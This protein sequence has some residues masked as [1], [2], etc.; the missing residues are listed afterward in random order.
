[1][2]VHLKVNHGVQVVLEFNLNIMTLQR[3]T[4]EKVVVSLFGL[5]VYVHHSIGSL[6]EMTIDVHSVLRARH[7]YFD[8]LESVFSH[9]CV[10]FPDDFSVDLERFLALLLWELV[11]NYRSENAA[12]LISLHAEAGLTVVQGLVDLSFEQEGVFRRF[13]VQRH[14][15]VKGLNRRVKGQDDGLFMLI[16]YVLSSYLRAAVLSVRA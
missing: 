16:V 4:E 14:L 13:G 11:L 2:A 7:M 12:F 3:S 6:A 5:E 15:T 10:D 8:S 1:M 9:R